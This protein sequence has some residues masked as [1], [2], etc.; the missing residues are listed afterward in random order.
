ME[1]VDLVL[2]RRKNFFFATNSQFAK[3]RAVC[4]GDAKDSF[5]IISR[6]RELPSKLDRSIK[7]GTADRCDCEY[8]RYGL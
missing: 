6:S 7:P 5:C 4:P 8:G 3:F 1:I 2:L